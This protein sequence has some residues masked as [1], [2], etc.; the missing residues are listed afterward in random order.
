MRTFKLV[1]AMVVALASV[2][3]GVARASGTAEAKVEVTFPIFI[4]KTRDL[5]FGNIVPGPAGGTVQMSTAGVRTFTGSPVAGNAADEGPAIF[6]VTGVAGEGYDIVLPDPFM[7]EGPGDDML[8]DGIAST[9]SGS[10]VLGIGGDQS[11]GVG[12]TLHV[13][14][15]QTPGA[16]TKSF[17]VTVTYN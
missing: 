15:D 6:K 9:P 1:A 4:E 10:G 16:Y 5:D 17:E 7:L 11:F 14:A 12:A 13:G 2:G 8:V 3:G